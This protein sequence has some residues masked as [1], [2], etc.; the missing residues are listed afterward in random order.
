[1]TTASRQLIIIGAGGFGRETAE[2]VDTVNVVHP[3]WDLLGF[4][5]DDPRL[6]GRQVDGLRVLGPIAAIRDY[7]NALIT[8][9][10]G[11]PG[12]FFSRKRIVEALDLPP[13]R[14][15]TLVHPTASV[16]LSARIGAGT[17]LLAGV[18]LTTRVIVGR[19]VVVMPGAVLTHDDVVDDFATLGAGV[20]L[21]GRVH[22]GQ[23]AYLGAGALVRENVTIGPWALIGM[24]AAV[25]HNVSQAEVWVGVPAHRSRVLDLPPE[26]GRASSPGAPAVLQLG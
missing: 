11:H 23:G 2:L 19:H 5:D 20:R 8:V 24:G 13:E 16:P 18:V 1:M 15:A 17:V 10:V 3:S 4:L 21:A 14:F 25:L 7:G 22:I 9:S 6:A 26:L 12:N